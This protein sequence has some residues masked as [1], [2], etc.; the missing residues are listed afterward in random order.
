MTLLGYRAYTAKRLAKT[1]LKHDEQNLKKLAAIRNQEEYISTVCQYIEE[2][3]LIIQADAQGPALLE[4]AWDAET[5]REEVKA[6][7]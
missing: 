5:I 7:S 2:L 1:F 3:E 6:M 4:G